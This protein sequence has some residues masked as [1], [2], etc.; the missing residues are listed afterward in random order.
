MLVLLWWPQHILRLAAKLF[1]CVSLCQKTGLPLFGLNHYIYRKGEAATDEL[2]GKQKR[3]GNS[4]LCEALRE[5]GGKRWLL[6]ARRA[7]QKEGR[8]LV[9]NDFRCHGLYVQMRKKKQK[10][11]WDLNYKCSYKRWKKDTEASNALLEAGL[12]FRETFFLSSLKK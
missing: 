12:E 9:G 10:G 5:E 7:M 6:K 11:R 2:A 3:R 4:G 8:G 1:V